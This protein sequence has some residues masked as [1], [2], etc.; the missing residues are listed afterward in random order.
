MRR[1]SPHRAA[2]TGDRRSRARFIA[3]LPQDC[4]LIKGHNTPLCRLLSECIDLWWPHKGSKPGP[5]MYD[6]APLLWSFDR[7][8]YPT[9]PMSLGIETRGYVAMGMTL[10]R[11]GPPNAEVSVGICVEEIKALYLST[12][13]TSE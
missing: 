1:I 3:F 7:S 8:Y 6:V 4:E 12:I 9:E 13:L 2:A 5:V 10:R 11:A